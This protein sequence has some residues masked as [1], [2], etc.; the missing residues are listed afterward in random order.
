M[1]LSV[2]KSLGSLGAVPASQELAQLDGT[3]EK[4]FNNDKKSHERDRNKS[5]L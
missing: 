1:A 4:I 5:R 3:K 2:M